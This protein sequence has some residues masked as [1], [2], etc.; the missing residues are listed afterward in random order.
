MIDHEL[1]M[2]ILMW[3]IMLAGVFGVFFATV[4]ADKKRVD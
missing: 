3:I 1:V 2:I 4:E